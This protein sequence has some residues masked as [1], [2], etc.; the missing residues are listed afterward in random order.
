MNLFIN[1]ESKRISD[2][3]LLD[4][5]PDTI[6]LYK[7]DFVEVSNSQL[8]TDLKIILLDHHNNYVEI[9][10]MMSNGCKKFRHSSDQLK[11]PT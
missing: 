6:H 4:C 11:R 7:D 8:D 1:H 3:K 9:S 2:Y 5:I 10:S